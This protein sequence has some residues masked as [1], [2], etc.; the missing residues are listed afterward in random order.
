MSLCNIITVSAG[1]AKAN[2]EP[3]RAKGSVVGESSNIFFEKHGL[4]YRGIDL[5]AMSAVAKAAENFSL[6][7]FK[8]AV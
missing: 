8:E 5:D 1:K 7:E 4:K 3:E 2:T 6:Q